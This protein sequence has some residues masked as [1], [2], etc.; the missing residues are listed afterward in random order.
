MIYIQLIGGLGNQLFVWAGAHKL[1]EMFSEPVCILNI[2]DK[3][4][5]DDRPNELN[6]LVQHCIH[7]INLRDTRVFSLFFRTIDRF[8]LEKNSLF[9]SILQRLGVYTFE[10]PAEPIK[11][12]KGKPRIVRCYFQ[13]NEYVDSIWGQICT[14]ILEVFNHTTIPEIN[15]LYTSQVIHF[16]RGDTVNFQS[17][18]GVLSID[19]FLRNL[20]PNLET[21]VCTD[22]Q[23]YTD[24]IEKEFKTRFILTP[25]DT[26]TWQSLKIFCGAKKFIGSNS[27]LSWWAAK[28]RSKSHKNSSILPLPWTVSGTNYENGLNIPEVK[29]VSAQFEGQIKNGLHR[30]K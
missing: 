21:L 6:G 5:R 13:R 2:I 27:T 11:F 7:E 3:N 4:L 8:E 15:R 17:T 19:Y 28:I 29:F 1:S 22:D 10:N 20:S 9:R 25:L 18:H 14:E 26:S 24:F 12:L 16:R 23:S 30:L